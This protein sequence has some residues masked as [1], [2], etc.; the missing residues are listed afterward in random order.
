[1]TSIKIKLQNLSQ[2]N[3]EQILSA[4]QRGALSELEY[5]IYSINDI[6]STQWLQERVAKMEFEEITSLI[7]SA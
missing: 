7:L 2:E 4:I 1:M 6:Q 3:K 5:I